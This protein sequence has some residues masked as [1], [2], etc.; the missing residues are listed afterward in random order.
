MTL[1]LIS[2]VLATA[3]E[4][5]ITQTPYPGCNTERCVRRMQR[6]GHART[7]RRWQRTV[8]PHNAYLTRIARCESELRWHISTGNGFY[9]GLQFTLRSWQ[10][11]GG[12][13][14]PHHATPL[15]Q[16][17]RAVRLSRLQGWGA[18]PVCRWA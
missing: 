7:L 5:V 18:W 2:L 11:A 14:Y 9:G 1:A 16:K 4:P 6:R 3:S 15:E 17:Y 13:G 10:A 8:A 12:S